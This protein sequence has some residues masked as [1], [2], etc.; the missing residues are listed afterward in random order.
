MDLKNTIKTKV[1]PVV[2]KYVWT[3][4]KAITQLFNA[5]TGGNEDQ[6]FS[7]R[8]GLASEAGK[9]WAV[10]L[11]EPLINLIFF[12]DKNAEG[13]RDHCRMSIERDEV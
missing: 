7:G 4:A 12:K 3:V 2:K 10:Y 8:T 5:L 13:K 11:A 9:Y 1:M 6:S